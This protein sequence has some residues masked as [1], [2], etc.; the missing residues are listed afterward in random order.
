MIFPAFSDGFM[1]RPPRNDRGIISSTAALRHNATVQPHV[2]T[3][4][5]VLISKS[6]CWTILQRKRWVCVSFCCSP[7]SY[8]V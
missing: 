3:N 5:A 6:S 4:F 7:F 8:L 2:H 1:S